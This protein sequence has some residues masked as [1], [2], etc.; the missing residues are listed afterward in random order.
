MPIF[1]RRIPLLSFLLCLAPLLVGIG[2]G[3]VEY[4]TATQ[5]E[6]EG[7]P[8][9]AVITDAWTEQGGWRRREKYYLQYEF[10][11]QRPNGGLTT[12]S[13]TEEVSRAHYRELQ[14][15]KSV[16]VLYIPSEPLI[17]RSEK[18]SVSKFAAIFLWLSIAGV[19]FLPGW[20]A[21]C[22][23]LAQSMGRDHPYS[24]YVVIIPMLAYIGLLID[25][26]S[27]S[28]LHNFGVVLFMSLIMP[29]GAAFVLIIGDV[30]HIPWLSDFKPR[31]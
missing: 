11:P 17:V 22:V 3:V 28:T 10:E 13:H 1:L 20:A 31:E 23:L 5:I 24:K 26:L 30:F 21:A 9:S 19:L 16:D 12:T 8:A 27:E 2:L 29:I 25:L 18:Y 15:V 7:I 14:N 4:K 6:H